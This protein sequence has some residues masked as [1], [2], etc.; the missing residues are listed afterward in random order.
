M[1]KRTC[2]I[3]GCERP[4][5]AR[6]WCEMHY[7][8]W[9]KRGDAGA[10]EPNRVWRHRSTTRRAETDGTVQPAV[11]A[12]DGC[13]RRRQAREWC[14]SHWARWRRT[15]DAGEAFPE[16]ESKRL[17]SFS[18]C[19]RDHYGL[20]LCVAHWQQQ[21]KGRPLTPVRAR[22]DTTERD[23]YG[24][25]ECQRC[26]QWL[27]E[28]AFYSHTGTRDRLAAQ[29][30]RC[31][32]DGRLIREYG[33]DVAWYDA[34]LAE[35]GGGCAICGR[36]SAGRLL[37]VDHDHSCCSGT[38]SCGKCVRAIL[39]DSCNRVLGLMGDSPERLEA[40]AAYLR[41]HRHG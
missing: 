30:Q 38:K 34:R 36:H 13:E 24:R 37:A 25:K 35:Q 32:R 11:C 23:E 20:G 14:K 18:G 26:S 6:G 5:W 40:A 31:H 16:P 17:C 8:R 21:H 27:P 41:G 19:S 15:G 28:D 7:D 9:K 1:T 22:V 39:C 4:H 2:V 10:A 29:C 12:V 3:D 33:V